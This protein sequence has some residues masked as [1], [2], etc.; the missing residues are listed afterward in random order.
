MKNALIIDI[1]ARSREVG[2][3]NLQGNYS[4]NNLVNQTLTLNPNQR[5]PGQS[6]FSILTLQVISGG[7]LL[8]QATKGTDTNYINQLINQTTVIDQTVDRFYITNTGTLPAIIN[9]TYNA[10]TSSNVVT[11]V[12]GQ[13][14]DVLLVADDIDGISEVGMTGQYTDLLG[15]PKTF[16]PVVATSNTLG[17]VIAGYGTSINEDGNLIT[18]LHNYAELRA[19][20]D[21]ATVIN[22]AEPQFSGTFIVDSSDTT[23]VDDG[24]IVIVDVLNRRWKRQFVD[25]ISLDWFGPAGDGVTLD[26]VPIQAA[27]QY[28]YPI[29]LREN[30]VYLM[31]QTVV[32]NGGSFILRNPATFKLADNII[33]N[34]D[35]DYAH[36]TALFRLQGMSRV[37]IGTNITFDHNKLNQTYPATYARPGRGSN[38]FRHNASVEICPDITNTYPSQNIRIHG[39]KFIN[40]Y[41]NGLALWQVKDAWIGEC[42]MENTTWSGISGAG[43]R[44][45]RFFRN[46]AYRCGVSAQFPQTQQTGDRSGIQIREFPIGFTFETEGIPCIVT[47]EFSNGG[48]SMFVDFSENYGEECGVETIF[49]RAIKGLSGGRNRSYNCGYSRP[50]G[51]PFYPGHIWFESVEG[52]NTDNVIYQDKVEDGDMKPDGIVA[53]AMT[54]DASALF[55]F[56]GNYHMDIRGSKV[57]SA[58][59]DQGNPIPGLLY[60][61]LRISSNVNAD[62]ANIDGTDNDGILMTN[63]N[64]F[65]NPAVCTHDSSANNSIILNTNQTQDLAVSGGPIEIQKYGPDTGGVPTNI[66]ALNCTVDEG[67]PVLVFNGNIN[68]V[69]FPPV[70]VTFSPGPGSINATSE[71]VYHSQDAP[72][73]RIC[74]NTYIGEN[75]VAAFQTVSNAGNMVDIGT[76][77][78]LYS[79]SYGVPYCAFIYASGA[80]TGGLFVTAFGG[81]IIF[82]PQAS[83]SLSL[84]S[85]G[86][87]RFGITAAD[88]GINTIQTDGLIGLHSYTVANLPVGMN[89]SICYA[90]NGL[91]V[92]ELPGAGSGVPVYYSGGQ[93]RVWSTDQPVSS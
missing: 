41:L 25:A 55:P 14:G 73:Y 92:G 54:G 26:D 43:L 47:G 84:F 16:N 31:S 40:S 12:N 75:A 13:T 33:V 37:D 42:V 34:T 51:S 17:G 78:S 74:K 39:A 29:E 35:T 38:P 61:G 64:S 58:K 22:I 52:A 86:R 32:K 27:V 23:S 81:P 30:A 46:N 63:M 10:A 45:V 56:V 62:H 4:R 88:D 1:S 50:L 76:T 44:N 93:W 72:F 21:S 28:D 77:S 11:S 48:I 68:N 49:G 80:N 69:A 83:R 6:G 79:G 9:L 91:K 36:F 15:I 5:Y 60:R 20:S 67:K 57:H 2:F 70:N 3:N 59:D 89:G 82:R 87:S 18:S 90:S 7:P 65:E 85:S 71:M 24:G 8:L 53:Y 66:F 19:Y